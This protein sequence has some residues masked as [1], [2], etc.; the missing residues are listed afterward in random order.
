MVDGVA[1]QPAFLPGRR[2]DARV[3]GGPIRADPVG[4]QQGT[5][6]QHLAEEPLGGVE[7]PPGGEQDVDRLAVLEAI[8]MAA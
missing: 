5:V 3:G 6:L 2:D 8:P 4:R 1:R 7:I